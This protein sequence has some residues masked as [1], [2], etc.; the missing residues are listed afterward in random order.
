MNLPEALLTE[1]RFVCFNKRK[2]PI[3]PGTGQLA[4]TANPRTWASYA[5]ALAGAD[6]YQLA[7]IGFMLGGGFAGVDLD[8]CRDK[9]TGQL[10]EA[11][12]Q[13]I[14]TLDSYT[15][16]SISGTGTHTLLRVSEE[17]RLP[18][19][20]KKMKPNGILRPD[21]DRATDQQ[22]KDKQGNLLFK[23]P[24]IEIYTQKRFFTL[25]GKRCGD[26]HAVNERTEALQRVIATF[27]HISVTSTLA[28]EAESI[29][30]LS[31]SIEQALQLDPVFRQ[32]W[33]GDRPNQDESSDDCALMGK[34]L[35]WCNAHIPTALYYFRESP[36]A[37]QKDEFHQH[38]MNREDYLLRTAQAA[39]PASSAAIDNQH[40]EQRRLL[41]PCK[42]SHSSLQLQQKLQ[43]L[44]PQTLYSYDDKGN[45]ELFADVY[46]DVARFNT[47]VNEWYVYNGIVWQK[48]AGAMAV[49][50]M[51][52]QLK[53]ELLRYS[54]G[55]DNES[56]QK[57][58]QKHVIK[59]GSRAVRDILLKDARDKHPITNRD[60]DHRPNL[61]NCPNGT[62]DLVTFEFRRHDPADLLSKVTRAAYQP[63]LISQVW[64]SFIQ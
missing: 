4:S 52:K 17:L 22:K 28:E 42:S 2:K 37:Q 59:W 32:Y 62:L 40:W 14:T 36:Y 10:S 26:C 20:K 24:A 8:T 58:F 31:P 33:N 45:G 1:R 48:D 39:M 53:D 56:Q 64:A 49:S 5:E 38:K 60:L 41:N 12:T 47:T 6:R 16:V 46:G 19:H 63:Q 55:I 18:F 9:E 25:T 30:P 54:L 13:I 23:E 15:E 3:N 27:D 44:Q 51:A 43:A 21:I 50:R 7:G 35:Y 29:I 34:L 11:A 61:L 57:V